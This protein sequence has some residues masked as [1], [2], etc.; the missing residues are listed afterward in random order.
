LY[1]VLECR[2]TV[3][4]RNVVAFVGQEVNLTCST[5]SNGVTWKR[6]NSIRNITE[7]VS[8]YPSRL[9]KPLQDLNNYKLTQTRDLD[10]N[11]SILTIGLNYS[12]GIQLN[13]SGIYWCIDDNSGIT[14]GAHVVV[15]GNVYFFII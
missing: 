1:D 13:D 12:I 9:S 14:H 8:Y 3:G 7:E 15:L 6:Q 10:T 2:I 5:T 4:P 11:T